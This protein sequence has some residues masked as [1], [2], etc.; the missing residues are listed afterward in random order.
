MKKTSTM[1][2]YHMKRVLLA[3]A[4]IAGFGTIAV[5]QTYRPLT[6][7]KLIINSTYPSGNALTLQTGTGQVAYTLTLPKAAPT[8][9]Y[10]LRSDIGSDGANTLIW[11]EPMSVYEF[12]NGL[13]ETG[14]ANNTVKWG[15]DLTGATII[16]TAGSNAITFYNNTA[17][18][19]AAL[20][21]GG[22]AGTLTLDVR[23][24]TTINT[25][26]SAATS[27]G[28]TDGTFTLLSSTGLNVTAAGVITDGDG[29]VTVD[30]NLVPNVHDNNTLGAD[31]AR[32]R[33]VYIGPSTLHIGTT[34]A[35]GDE[36]ALSYNT[37]DNKAVFNVGSTN[38]MELTSSALT[39]AAN[40]VANG[41]T[42][43]GNSDGGTV[44]IHSTSGLTINSENGADAAANLVLTESQI[45]RENELTII[46]KNGA[47]TQQSSI[48]L[49]SNVVIDASTLGGAVSVTSSGANTIRSYAPSTG[50]YASMTLGQAT[51][52]IELAVAVDGAG[53]SLTVADDANDGTITLDADAVSITASLV[54]AINLPATGAS[55]DGIVVSASG[56]LSTASVATMVETTVW[57]LDGNTTSGVKTIGSNDAYAIGIETN[58]TT[59]LTI[60]SDGAAT[61]TGSLTLGSSS[62]PASLYLYD[63]GGGETGL[64]RTS[65]LGSNRTYTI[66]VD[67]N[68]SFVMTE[69]AQTINGVKTLSAAT[70]IQGDLT[71]GTAGSATGASIV[72]HDDAIGSGNTA[73]LKI[74]NHGG[75]RTYT[76][77]DIS[78][79][80]S[81]VMTAGTQ[82]IGGAKTFS[83]A[84]SFSSTIEVT[85]TT[86]LNGN[87]NI[88]N[89]AADAITIAGTIAG[90]SPLVFEGATN[91]D[92]FQTTFAISGP[93]ADR[94]LTFPDVTGTVITTGNTSDLA[95][96]T[97]LV[98][99]NT[100]T[101]GTTTRK[102]GI[103]A[104]GAN[105]DGFAIMTDGVDR[106]T[107]AAGGTSTFSGDVAVTS[108]TGSTSTTTGSLV[109]TGGAGVS[110]NV[111]IGGT[112]TT[113]G[114]TTL[115]GAV[116]A[117]GAV[118]L[119]NS[120]GDAVSIHSTGGLTVNTENGADAAANLTITEEMIS[121]NNSLTLRGKN[122][123]GDK[124]ADVVLTENVSITASTSGGIVTATSAGET[125]IRSYASASEV[126]SLN[127]D[128]A[129]EF[130]RLEVITQGGT[131]PTL[132]VSDDAGLGTINLQS[133]NVVISA[134]T[135]EASNIP[136]TGAS[137]DGVVVSASGV[138]KTATVATLVG[139]SFWAL[140]GNTTGGTKTIGSN[141]AYTV[142]I[143]TNG[144]TRLTI[145]SDGD[146]TFSNTLTSTGNL[147]VGT[148][149]FTVAAATGN[150]VVNGS[151]TLGTSSLQ[152][153]LYLFDN[154]GGQK[155]LIQTSG[156]T[157]DRTYTIDVNSDASFVMTKGAQT[158]DGAKTFGNITTF[159]KGMQVP[160]TVA[161]AAATYAADED[162][163]VII[164]TAVQQVT[165]P[166]GDT[167]RII[168]VKNTSGSNITLSAGADTFEGGAATLSLATATSQ[169]FI[170]SGGV[171]Y[172]I[173]N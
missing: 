129:G 55:S 17:A 89:A 72:F 18:T 140:N 5:A 25:S 38:T 84:A 87:V 116:T 32:W 119:G 76:M 61:Q 136:A 36:L 3:L 155:G 120:D 90:A 160:V 97:W 143:E 6:N 64:I 67:N 47:A 132:T 162:D 158:I 148:S 94:T 51:S 173:G 29:D 115:T 80:A 150:T 44:T 95:T 165:F 48:E 45:R 75:N 100:I 93:T 161:T 12:V 81:F 35:G 138:L 37:T 168:I 1:K 21:I 103:A 11:S 113:T 126:A 74:A 49:S 107:I 121:R 79:D 156:L 23:G 172:L 91:G 15:G 83:D 151:L 33:D 28:N 59:W 14:G 50:A 13:T 153:S 145:N 144:S 85:G 152:A 70:S 117:N 104:Q 34:T 40:L 27:I 53:P 131:G 167:G 58:G 82:T 135:I 66:D 26:G 19:T 147:T 101:G 77:D 105:D 157:S 141:D 39:L 102:I 123:I 96:L 71:L 99:G 9:G 164:Q 24:S 78:A 134:S 171:W 146:A 69:G 4:L 86:T 46:G 169:T 133:D 43:L 139:D 7:T 109:V 56:M 41:S 54:E 2:A 170:Y 65:G 128:Q 31:A 57:M 10:F 30:D 52:D 22:G 20:T 62:A 163:M 92:G 111:F 124:Q 112:L 127:L 106:L 68:A 137:S 118:T 154:S 166:T 16:N 73:T 63:D 42:T 142:G 130:A 98:G 125:L 8:A 149:T 110:E 122:T 159:S 108:N 60:N 88:G 114:A